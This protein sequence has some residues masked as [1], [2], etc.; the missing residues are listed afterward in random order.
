MSGVDPTRRMRSK[1]P[2]SWGTDI[3][4][5]TSFMI[6]K[7]PSNALAQVIGAVMVAAVL[8]GAP[9]ILSS[10]MDRGHEIA[11][12][13]LAQPIAWI[14][15]AAGIWGSARSG[16]LITSPGARLALIFLACL[17]ALA[18]V[19]TALSDDPVVALLG[20]YYR[21]DGL[22]SW[23]S[24]S[25][26]CVAA[27][28]VSRSPEKVIAVIDA[29]ILACVVP[30]VYALLQR[31]DL[32]F[33]HV[34]GHEMNR[35]GSTLGSPL[36]LGAY[37]GLLIPL[38]IVR[39][40]LDRR[41]PAALAFWIAFCALELVTLLMTLSRGPIL[42]MCVGLGLL[43]FLYAG[44]TRSRKLFLLVGGAFLAIVVFIAAINAIP[45]VKRTVSD[46]P[47]VGR[48]VHSS[49]ATA[50]GDTLK[51]TGSTSTRLSVWESGNETFASSSTMNQLIGFG[52]DLAYLKL[53]PHFPDSVMW[54]DGYWQSNTFDR[55]H[56]DALD[57]GLSFGLLGWLAYCFFFGSVL[58]HAARRLF[59]HTGAVRP[60][61][62]LGVSL[63]FGVVAAALVLATGLPAALAPVFAVGIGFGWIAF[64]VLCSWRSICAHALQP[65]NHPPGS[66]LLLA[67]LTTSLIVFWLD[68]QVN[69]PVLTT[70]FISFA[71]AGM[72]LAL[73][74]RSESWDETPREEGNIPLFLPI[75]GLTVSL[76]ATIAGLFPLVYSDGGGAA[77]EIRRWWLAFVPLGALVAAGGAYVMTR[78]RGPDDVLRYWI[79]FAAI[80]PTIYAACHWLLA[81]PMEPEL[82]ESVVGRLVAG[83]SIAPLFILGAGLFYAC[84]IH[85]R[86]PPQ[87][88]ASASAAIGQRSGLTSIALVA[89][90]LLAGTAWLAIRTDIGANLAM[91]TA[92]KQPQLSEAVLGK[93][94]RLAPHER[95][96]QRQLV[97]HHLGRALDAI[98]GL[99]SAP[100]SF[101]RIRR[102]L[103]AAEDQ[104]RSSVRRFPTDPWIIL[105][106]A[107][108]RQ[109]QALPVIR[110][111]IGAE[112]ARAAEEADEL[113]EKAYEIFPNQPLLLRNWA[114]L[115]F[116]EGDRL[117]AYRL[118]DKMERII[119]HEIEPYS[120]RIFYARRFGDENVV[121]N[122]IERARAKLAAPKYAKL[123]T[124]LG[125]AFP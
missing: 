61:W 86:V 31:L 54:T 110:S 111:L 99:G 1:R 49:D 42:A 2:K 8:C 36:F 46:W 65:A 52:P 20:N 93:V 80:V 84:T 10:A 13:S 15:L 40:W 58:F 14:A 22:L 98:R 6:L 57:T 59:G 17:M 27:Y 32:D 71:I 62:F 78:E 9:I 28:L 68:A 73:A 12:I 35:P 45:V 124:D 94:I 123:T 26:F 55:L 88:S 115:K 3:G 16:R 5:G 120:E 89:A 21:R 105:A 106:L 72:I 69:I 114:Q 23:I 37:A 77:D 116:N 121:S 25:A 82:T 50:S 102:D 39:A 83:T 7:A 75:W 90:L 87:S 18:G 34:V 64:L 30:C 29:M 24:Y 103:E 38:S 108:V 79:G 109:I 66:W 92:S 63:G 107:N 11:K 118:L 117:N 70:R 53:F 81:V 56:A 47:V 51:A 125:L 33:F 101:P 74:T 44:L 104:A 85:D 96:Y 67:A 41:K 122:T 100:D 113:Y 97:F 112:G 95:Q 119:P 4:D 43:T 91:W 19:S 76:I 60:F 48:F